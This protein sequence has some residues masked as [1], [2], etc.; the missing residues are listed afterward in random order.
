MP[1]HSMSMLWLGRIHLFNW[2]I[3]FSIDAEPLSIHS[4]KFL[5]VSGPYFHHQMFTFVRKYFFNYHHTLAQGIPLCF[6]I[7]CVVLVLFIKINENKHIQ[8]QWMNENQTPH[9]THSM[10]I[11]KYQ[12]QPFY[13]LNRKYFIHNDHSKAAKFNCARCNCGHI[14]IRIE[15]LFAL[16][17]LRGFRIGITRS[18]AV[19]SIMRLKSMLKIH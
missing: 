9:F 5:I 2:Y 16:H 15:I 3:P 10:R 12:K 14:K 8:M 18:G 11:E 1:F 17:T 7:K 4:R 19:M 6:D 13:Y